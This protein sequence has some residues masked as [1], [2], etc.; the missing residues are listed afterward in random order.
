MAKNV[1]VYPEWVEK[2]RKKGVT[3]RKTKYG[4]GLYR[5]TSSYVKGKK[6][7]QT[8]QEFLGMVYE[9]KGFVPKYEKK[10]YKKPHYLEYGLSSFIMNNFRRELLRSSYDHNQDIVKLGVI[11][12]IFGNY[13]PVC[14]NS[15]YLTCGDHKL[16]EYS[17]TA[18]KKRIRTIALNV[19]RCLKSKISDDDDLN[20]LISLL[21]LSVYDQSNGI[22]PEISDELRKL[23]EKY[24]VK[25]W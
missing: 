2:Y 11:E 18:S 5:C 10:E 3:I 6:Y 19:K 12:Y 16:M 20:I 8:V 17:C 25:P 14:L 15:C 13:S 1:N 21:R 23:S 22:F 7:P 9:D 4:Y 24:G